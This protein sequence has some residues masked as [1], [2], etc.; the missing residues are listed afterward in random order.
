MDISKALIELNKTNLLSVTSIEEIYRHYLDGKLVYNRAFSSPFRQDENPSFVINERSHYY[1]DFA[2]GESGDIFSFVQQIYSYKQLNFYDTMKQIA[3]DMNLDHHFTISD[4]THCE[5][6][7]V[8]VKNIS[9]RGTYQG[10]FHLQ[11]KVRNYE[12]YDLDFWM[13]FGIDKKY[14]KIGRIFPISHYFINGKQFNAEKF[15]YVYVEVKDGVETYKVYQPYSRYMKW[16]NNN[17]YSVWELWRLLP[18]TYDKMIITSS[19]KDALCI[20]KHF[21]IPSTSF[22]AESICP[23]P[24][25]VAD[26]QRRFPNVYLFYDNDF[27]N[28]DNPGQTLAKKRIDQFGFTNL[29]LPEKYGCKDFSD[30]IAEYGVM[31]SCNVLSQVMKA[32]DETDKFNPLSA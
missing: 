28:P 10:D 11:V 20:I 27:D 3:M 13:K 6:K 12:Q 1:K 29:Y 17:D 31:F 19:R 14:L 2:T 32:A 7:V 24:H 9:A 23:K 21:R 22:Q 5:S 15:A 18:E 8:E 4:K 25:V 30:L 26:I 16:I